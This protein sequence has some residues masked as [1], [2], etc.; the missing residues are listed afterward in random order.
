LIVYTM[1]MDKVRSIATLKFV[2]AP[3]RTIIGLIVQQALSL[4]LVGF[5][6]GLGLVLTFQPYFPRRLVL[7]PESVAAV[8]VITVVICLAA[9][10]LG[11][12]LALKVDPAAAL[13]AAG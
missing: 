4:G 2:G 6:V 11:V 10:S 1:T 8:F 13:A 3:D 12:R 5:V 9:S 7:D